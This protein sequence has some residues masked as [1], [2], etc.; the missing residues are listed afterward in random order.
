MEDRDDR[1]HVPTDSARGGSTPNIMRWVLG[2]S[3]LAAIILLSFIWMTGAAI[4]DGDG[5]TP[6][7]TGRVEQGANGS[8]STDGLVN[9]GT[10]EF[11]NAPETGNTDA[12]RVAN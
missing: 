5:D 8:S 11:Q 2:I 4:H 7:A 6:T 10:D 3:L 1:V 9:E 12:D